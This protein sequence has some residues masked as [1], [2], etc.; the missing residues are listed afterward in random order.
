MPIVCLGTCSPFQEIEPLYPPLAR[1]RVRCQ[2]AKVRPVQ[3]DR[4]R[5]TMVSSG[6]WVNLYK[7]LYSPHTQLLNQVVLL[8]LRRG[9]LIKVSQIKMEAYL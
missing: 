7:L 2:A 9:R 5:M 4:K 1:P 3:D 6:C 8:L